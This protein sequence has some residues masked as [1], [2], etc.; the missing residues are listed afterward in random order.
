MA[1]FQEL[2]FIQKYLFKKCHLPRQLFHLL[3]QF[4]KIHLYETIIFGQ[5]DMQSFSK[6]MSLARFISFV[7]MSFVFNGSAR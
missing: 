2:L 4:I 5:R 3:E 6:I 7:P 1:H